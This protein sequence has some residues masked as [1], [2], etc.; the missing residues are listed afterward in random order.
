MKT[1]DAF[2]GSAWFLLQ[3]EVECESMSQATVLLSGGLD[4]TTA[5]Y[6]ALDAFDKVSALIFNYDQ[7][8]IV[9]VAMAE[10]TADLLKVPRRTI[11][12]PFKNLLAS[13]L[14]DGEDQIP[15]SLAT[16][17]DET[18]V[19]YTYVPFRNGIFLSIAAAYS[20]SREVYNLVTGFNL[21]DTP[22]YPD[23]TVS[24]TQKMAAA[25]NQGTAAQKRGE[26]FVI[27]TPLIGLRK[28]EI[29]LK[30]IQL[31][32]DYAY[33][34]SCYRGGEVPCL[35]CPSCD[36]RSRAFQELNLS[37]PLLERLKKEGKF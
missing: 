36:I 2:S 8:H 24:F 28:A 17:K 4:S 20:E 26:T 22:D 32:A 15:D 29:I 12:L 7:T 19:P 31:G 18:G 5:L 25:I 23:T 35:S 9:E 21:V 16:A 34:I 10:K 11:H 14:I 3:K 37:D 33:S 1:G 30:G 6:W 27:H 13:A